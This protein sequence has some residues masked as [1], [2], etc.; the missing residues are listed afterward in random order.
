MSI[1]DELLS[2]SFC[3]NDERGYP[4][5]YVVSIE[6]RTNDGHELEL[7]SPYFDA[8]P[9]FRLGSARS[10]MVVR[11]GQRR[12]PISSY[13]YHVGNFCW[14]AATM[15]RQAA[16]ECV[17]HALGWGFIITCCTDNHPLLEAHDGR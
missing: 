17:K 2:V 5:G 3:C 4:Q 16:R 15:T 1:D 10:E 11:V 12:F 13:R 8:G 7:E 14:D 9:V 6:I